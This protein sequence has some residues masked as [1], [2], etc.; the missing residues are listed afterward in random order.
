MLAFSPLFVFEVL[1]GQVYDFLDESIQKRVEGDLEKQK[2][3]CHFEFRLNQKM[4]PN[5]MSYFF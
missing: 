4:C 5:K 1:E 2:K 3:S